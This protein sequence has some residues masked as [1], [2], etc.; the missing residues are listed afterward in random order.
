ML[1]GTSEGAPIPKSP[2]VTFIIEQAMKAGPER[3]L[4]LV[5]LGPLTNV[6]SALLQAPDIAG[7]I[8]VYALG[9]Q[10]NIATGAW[11]KNEFNARNDLN[12]LDQVLSNEQVE[13]F[14]MPAST[15]AA[16]TLAQETTAAELD[17]Y[18]HPVTQLLKNRW[19]DVHAGKEWIMWDLALME[20]I[21]H[22]EWATIKVV[23]GPP[24]NGGR[25]VS[26][27]THIGGRFYAQRFGS[28]GLWIFLLKETSEISCVKLNSLPTP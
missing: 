2:A 4:D 6:A 8:R 5:V 1:G 3:K 27:F 15:A 10:Y 7:I 25:E 17:R 23:S 19:D 11:D 9:M 13:L 22:P 26:V 14:V 28:V 21:L 18:R 24:E 16:L 12:A 20:A